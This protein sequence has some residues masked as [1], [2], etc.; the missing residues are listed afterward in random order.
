M[1]YGKNGILCQPLRNDLYRTLPG[2]GCST[3]AT[4]RW[5]C[6]GSERWKRGTIALCHCLKA[7]RQAE[8]LRCLFSASARFPKFMLSSA[9]RFSECWLARLFSEILYVIEQL[10][11]SR[12]R[13][14]YSVLGRR[15]GDEGLISAF[16]FSECSGSRQDMGIEIMILWVF[17]RARLPSPL[18]QLGTGTGR[19]AKSST[20]SSVQ[21]SVSCPCLLDWTRLKSAL[22]GFWAVWSPPR[23]SVFQTLRCVACYRPNGNAI[24]EKTRKKQSKLVNNVKSLCFPF[25]R[26]YF[27]FW[28]LVSL[29]L[30]AVGFPWHGWPWPSWPEDWNP[31]AAPGVGARDLH[32]RPPRGAECCGGSQAATTGKAWEN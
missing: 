31:Q 9:N 11:E 10:Q 19:K 3:S 23:S 21:S 17:W 28:G 1:A 30:Y 14:I 4:C 22:V 32:L 2:P 29:F 12:I 18:F 5:S 6:T 16:N 7:W 8:A 24:M 13:P 27:A 26:F 25:S 20:R 15:F